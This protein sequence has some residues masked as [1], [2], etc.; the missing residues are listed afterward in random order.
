MGIGDRV[1]FP[2]DLNRCLN[3][4]LALVLALGPAAVG[5]GAAFLLTGH[6]GIGEPVKG[7]IP[8]ASLL[9][10]GQGLH[11]A[12]YVASLSNVITSFAAAAFLVLALAALVHRPLWPLFERPLYAVQKL[13]IVRRTKLLGT[14]GVLL[15]GVAF[16][17][18][19]AWL[20]EL[21]AGLSPQ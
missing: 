11:E 5:Y 18:M 2:D 21:L 12:G 1:L 15:L 13:G 4:V 16:G 9:I 19:P 17:A 7:T 3:C 20:R 8:V 6:S 14:D 10:W